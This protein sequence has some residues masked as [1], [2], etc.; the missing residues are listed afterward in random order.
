[1]AGVNRTIHFRNNG[2]ISE[3]ATILIDGI[4]IA[5]SVE[6]GV[7]CDVTIIEIKTRSQSSQSASI[8][9]SDSEV[10][11]NSNSEEMSI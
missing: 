3:P 6:V 10:S 7:V 2:Q 4:D 11:H 1:M 5:K 8:C 9:G